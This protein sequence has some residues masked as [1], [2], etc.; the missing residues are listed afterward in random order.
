MF[1]TD[2]IVGKY[3][4]L[5][6]IHSGTMSYLFKAQD[7]QQNRLVALKVLKQ[8]YTN[9]PELIERFQRE[10]KVAQSLVHPNIIK[11]FDI[12]C[13]NNSNY[14]TM[15]F[16][17]GPN[18]RKVIE[19]ENP[20][21]VNKAC[22]TVRDICLG[23]N[24]A[25]NA[26][27]FHRDIKPS[28][29]M[30][31]EKNNV[32]ICDFGIAKVAYLAKITRV[33]VVLGTWEY[34]SPEQIRGHVVDGR[35]DLYSTGIILYEMLTGITPF[36]GKD[37]WEIADRI[38]KENPPKPSEINKNVPREID[39]IILKSIEKDR[40][41]RF[42]SGLEMANVLNHFLGLP[43]EKQ[44]VDVV[45]VIKKEEA[46]PISK[47]SEKT[48]PSKIKISNSKASKGFWIPPVIAGFVLLFIIVYLKA[49]QFLPV[50]LLFIG[51]FGILF[52]LNVFKTPQK[53][54]K[55]SN[56]Q[57]IHTSGND[58]IQVFPLNNY[59]V[60]IG[61]DQPDGIEIFKDTISRS[62]SKIR[63]ENGYYVIYDLNSKNGTYVNNNKIDRYVLKN[64]DCINIGGEILI[65]QG[66]K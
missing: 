23:L 2:S 52:A 12:G 53:I 46:K 11:V 54:A 50:L 38:I 22:T 36:K 16:I 27:V 15:Q 60:V 48:P 47:T 26:K 8:E 5:E 20:L 32:I 56:A 35:A 59:E 25:H 57:L 43:L 30:L 18:L 14:F 21:L 6:E 9:E 40:T 13:E 58:I 34:T 19:V 7:T 33:G 4:I 37:Y 24:Y 51:F 3:K 62:N 65:F 41:R 61:R 63:N 49:P 64:K 45:S 1:E 31:D 55:Y 17:N 29:I 66:V 10:A 39:E 44:K 28:N 42:S